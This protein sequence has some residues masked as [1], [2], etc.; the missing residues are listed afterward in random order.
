MGHGGNV[1]D[2]FT[3]DHREVE[4]LFARIETQ[5]VGDDRR[6][7][8]ADELMVELTR[9]AVAEEAY[10]YPAVREHVDDGDAIAD[11]AIADHG[12]VEELLEKLQGRDADDPDFDDLIARLRLDVNE[13]VRDE[14]NRLFPLLAA[15]CPA[16][17]L[18]GLG[19]SVR[20]VE[21]T[22][23]GRAP[24]AGSNTAPADERRA[25][26]VGAVGRVRDL[27]SGGGGD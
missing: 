8:L 19:D 23:P 17:V 13:H 10:L 3:A 7:A 6:R 26:H 1:I 24:S 2:E 16:A 21:R 12:G 9:H 15:A 5:P 4:A 14:E 18:T 25:P 20:S 27:P 11:R 22:P